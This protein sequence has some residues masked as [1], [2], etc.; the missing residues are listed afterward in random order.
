M[1][2]R[3][4][5]TPEQ[6][7]FDTALEYLNAG[8][9][10][11]YPTETFYGL[12]VTAGGAI[13]GSDALRRLWD[14]KRRPPDKP[15]PLIAADI[16]QLDGLVAE[17]EPEELALMEKYWPGPLTILFK[18]KP[19]LSPFIVSG[20]GRVAVRVP[21]HSAALRLVK[22]VRFPITATSANIANEPPASEAQAVIDYFSGSIDMVIDGGKT[23][24]APASTIVE[25]SDGRINVIRPGAVDL[26]NWPG[27][28]V[29]YMNR[30]QGL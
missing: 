1:L 24:G 14:L 8:K 17:I 26:V 16:T 2:L 9:I 6:V 10:I 3:L 11:A 22:H 4:S 13:N 15:F 18:A 25:I 19:G 5:E 28:P 12:G 20:Q 7:I 27:L 23:K 30:G 21:G 29:F